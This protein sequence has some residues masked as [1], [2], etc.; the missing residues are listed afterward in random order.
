MLYDEY[1]PIWQEWQEEG[2]SL[3][4]ISEKHKN[5]FGTNPSKSTVRRKLSPEAA[6][7]QKKYNEKKDK[8]CKEKIISN[9]NEIKERIEQKEGAQTIAKNLDIPSCRIKTISEVIKNK[10]V[11]EKPIRQWPTAYKNLI[12]IFE[13]PNNLR[14]ILNVPTRKPIPTTGLLENIEDYLKENSG[15][16]LQSKI[17]EKFGNL[18]PRIT[19]NISHAANIKRVRIKG[20]KEWVIYLPQHKE[21]AE[22]IKEEY[23]KNKINC[24]LEEVRNE[25]SYEEMFDKYSGIIKNYFEGSTKKARK[26]ASV[27]EEAWKD[28]NEEYGLIIYAIDIGKFLERKN[29]G[30]KGKEYYDALSLLEERKRNKTKIRDDLYRF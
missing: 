8:E 25:L 22:K 19:D 28:L 4:E 11:L 29:Y 26:E 18:V 17:Y 15:C 6:E 1:I 3:G 2:L 23:L 13:S 5:E 9:F 27:V 14:K 24:F 21:K 30:L 20:T 16:E 10:D 12:F 7:W